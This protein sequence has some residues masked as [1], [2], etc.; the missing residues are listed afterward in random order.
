MKALHSSKRWGVFNYPLDSLS[1][2]KTRIL[3]IFTTISPT[4]RRNLLPLS[5]TLEIK[6]VRSLKNVCK[7]EP[8]T[9]RHTPKESFPAEHVR[10]LL[11]YVTYVNG[12]FELLL[13]AL[14]FFLVTRKDEVAVIRSKFPNKVPVSRNSKTIYR[15]C[16]R[17]F[18][19]II[20]V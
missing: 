10:L 16:H 11:M 5:S 12:P 4:F 2:Q 8:T 13:M 14:F 18:I 20:E 9:R 15:M 1:S 3:N 19:I 17:M 7:F 6:V